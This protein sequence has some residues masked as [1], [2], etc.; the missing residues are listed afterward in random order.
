MDSTGG[1][2]DGWFMVS[3]KD[4]AS[5]SQAESDPDPDRHSGRD[6]HQPVS[7]PVSQKRSL[8]S[9]KSKQNDANFANRKKR[10]FAQ[11]FHTVT[12][13]FRSRNPSD[14][15]GFTEDEH[16]LDEP[17]HDHK[18]EVS[19]IKQPSRRQARVKQRSQ[20]PFSTSQ[21]NSVV[22]KSSP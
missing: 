3:K 1:I 19:T 5:H 20:S 21:N 4:Q 9:W 6:S 15:L 2:S 18:I 14:P 11:V 10:S 7:Q 8:E 16:H 17:L 22:I 12:V 13:L